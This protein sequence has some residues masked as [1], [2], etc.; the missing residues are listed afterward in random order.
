[1]MKNRLWQLREKMEKQ[2]LDSLL[3]TSL[4]NRRY[5]SGFTGSAGYLLI[6]LDKA[7]LLTDFRY[8][9]QAAD[10]A[11][12]F[13][14]IR[15]QGTLLEE[16]GK[17]LQITQPSKI[18]FEKQYVSYALYEGLQACGANGDWIGT[19]GIV[20]EL[21]MIKSADE[22]A[23]IKQAC[24]M[25]D[26]TFK[27]ILGFIKPGVSER[28]VALEIEFYMRKLGA[29][30]SSFD[31]IVAS[32]QRGALPHG[33][34]S[35]KVIQSGELVTMDFGAY[36][37]G[38]ISDLTRTVAV[39]EPNEKLREIYETVLKAQLRGVTEIRPGLT[40]KE[41]DALTRE[42]I[43]EAGYGECFGHST[44]HG[45]GLEVHEGPGLSSKSDVVLKPGMV[46]TVEPGIYLSQLGGVRIEDDILITENGCEIITQSTKE[47][48]I[49]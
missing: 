31:I 7:L 17:Q 24:Q 35:D 39:G 44:G 46:V 3:I 18:G 28:D 23:V 22:I 16:V 47:L 40:G 42:V 13:E 43:T 48:I 49:L 26:N 10:Q 6:T 30:S 9:D 15:H 33:V 20:E 27:H 12:D 2:G 19:Q 5:L 32:G 41:A 29:K 34:A 37:N 36:Y 21:R 25:A 1:M 14:V 45:I 4:L 38:Y 8:E 11:P